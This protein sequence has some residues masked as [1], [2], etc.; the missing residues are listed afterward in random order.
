MSIL[1]KLTLALGLAASLAL[2]A[3]GR[4]DTGGE[5][6]PAA[7]APAPAATKGE[8]HELGRRIYNFRCYFCHGYSG[9]AQTLAAT[10]L[11]PRPRN[12]QATAPDALTRDSMLEAV[13]SG[14]P[15]SAMRGFAGIL[16]PAEMEAVVDFVRRE[17]MADKAP[18]TRYHTAENGWADHARYDAAFPFATGKLA[19]DT[20]AEGL[21]PEQ[22]AGRALFMT[23][24]ISCHDRAKV[25]DPGAAWESRPLS[26]PRNGFAPGDNTYTP[27]R[28]A[29]PVD[30]VTSATPYHLH[31]Q[32][33]TLAN[34]SAQERRGET[35]FQQNCAFCHA[36]D[37]T[38]RNWIGSF[39]EPHPRDLTAD[40]SM[41]AMT[42]ARLADVIRDGLPDTSMPAWK[43]VLKPAEIDALVAYVERAFHA[44]APR[45]GRPSTAPNSHP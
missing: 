8:A 5:A 37:G 21:T 10:Y 27:G 15:G 11:E 45:A 16:K 36:A 19:L 23:S 34:P 4:T 6:A 42:R 41:A 26:Y 13:K 1:V 25:S 31:D 18:N 29:P 14:R 28:G 12:F 17:F 38:A 3:A 30:A 32:A 22:R 7:L 35:L 20:P 24:C 2:A 43:A 33:P 44:L 9:D 40:A 39:L